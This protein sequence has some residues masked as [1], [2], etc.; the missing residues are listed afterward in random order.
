MK[1]RRNRKKR[2]DTI[3]N[4]LENFAEQARKAAAR[5][6]AG[7]DRNALLRKA[8]MSD[9]AKASEWLASAGLQKK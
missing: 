7:E 9:E 5:L 2:T 8:E 1:R 6:P 3:F 4:R